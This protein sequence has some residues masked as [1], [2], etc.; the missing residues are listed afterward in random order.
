MM[1]YRTWLGVNG[2][3]AAQS[4]GRSEGI[5]AMHCA[6]YALHVPPNLA[7]LPIIASTDRMDSCRMMPC[8]FCGGWRIARRTAY[9]YAQF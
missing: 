2:Q 4:L 8:A 1:G 7:F 9:R 3:A 5:A 6:A